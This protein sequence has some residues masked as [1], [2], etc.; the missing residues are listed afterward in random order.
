MVIY[1]L[2]ELCTG[3][4]GTQ[5]D[6]WC[7]LEMAQFESFCGLHAFPLLRMV[8]FHRLVGLDPPPP[9]RGLRPQLLQ[10]RDGGVL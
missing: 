6:K 8:S 7:R 4:L 2:S 10:R 9:P 3:P 5:V 1:P